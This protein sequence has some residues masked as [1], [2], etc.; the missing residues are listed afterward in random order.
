L[1]DGPKELIYELN[2]SLWSTWARRRHHA[3]FDRV[4]AFCLFVGYP[5]SGHSIVGALLNAHR[6]AVI[7]HELK[8][9]DLILAGC[10]R[11]DLYARILSRAYWFH[12]RGNRANYEYH[13]PNQWQGRFATLRVIG[14]KRGGLVSRTLDEHPDFL[15]RVRALVGVPLRLVHVVRNPFDNISAI[16]VSDGRPLAESVEYYFGHCRATARLDTLARPGEVFSFR[17]EDMV[18]APVATLSA[19]CGFLGL[20]PYPSYLEDCARVVFPKPT[21]TR[22]KVDWPDALVR[23]VE[24]RARAY[25]FLDGYRFALTDPPAGA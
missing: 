21:H 1:L 3:A 13:V 16:A 14:D 6:D 23:E 15:E 9:S 22:R 5:R 18:R 7:A 17:H 8:A 2:Q 24:R 25:P 20:E 10:S 4:A 11:D 19:L 12:L